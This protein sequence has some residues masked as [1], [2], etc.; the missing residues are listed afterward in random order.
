M[1]ACPSPPR[2]GSPSD[3]QGFALDSPL[4]TPPGSIGAAGSLERFSSLSAAKQLMHLVN[5]GGLAASGD[6]S[7]QWRFI[8]NPAA[9]TISIGL[10]P[11]ALAGAT[12]AERRQATIDLGS[13][14]EV[15]RSVGAAYGLWPE[16]SLCRGGP[17]PEAVL[18][19]VSFRGGS[20]SSRPPGSEEVLAAVRNR[21][22]NRSGFQDRSAPA[23]FVDGLKKA[24]REV[25]LLVDYLNDAPTRYALS[26]GNEGAR[27][28]PVVVASVRS[29]CAREW[30]RT[31]M[32]FQRCVIDSERFGL[33]VSLVSAP[34][35]NTALNVMLRARLG[36]LARPALVFRVGFERETPPHAPRIPVK[37]RNI[38]VCDAEA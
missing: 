1:H 9:M 8:L 5:W 35:E 32:F 4:P 31:G 37:L 7:R 17:S 25:G 33:S 6:T 16:V 30:L 34:V 14:V 3:P 26:A 10:D 2:P 21:P 29:D 12:D 20:A 23:A 24:G 19:T 11:A 22:M 27:S 13:C 15:I 28:A 38:I 18:A 36:R